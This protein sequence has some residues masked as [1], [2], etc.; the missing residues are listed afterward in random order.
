MNGGR[1]RFGKS[2]KGTARKPGFKPRFRREEAGLGVPGACRFCSEKLAEID[3]KD[4]NRLKRSITEKGKIFSSR[5]TG[6]CAKHQ[7]QLA[8]A[9][10]RAR[11]IALLPYVG[12]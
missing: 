1:S 3:Y 2:S 8:T 7:R 4:I 10:K 11:F 9:V 12:E 5:T 6:I